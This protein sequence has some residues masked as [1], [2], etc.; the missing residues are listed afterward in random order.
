MGKFNNLITSWENIREFDLRPLRNAA[1]HPV[2]IA[3]VGEPGCGRHTLADQM[4]CD[5]ARPHNTT[6]TPLIFTDLQSPEAALGANLIILITDSR[7]GWSDREQALLQHWINAEKKVL[8][9]K[10]LWHEAPEDKAA[11]PQSLSTGE[12]L[13]AGALIN[14]QFI[15]HS[16]VPSVLSLLPDQHVALGRQFPLFRQAIA[17]RL[18]DDTCLSNAAYALSTGIAEAIPIFD[19]P[20]NVTDLIVL[21]KTQAFLAYKLG[22][23]FGFSTNWQDYVAEFGSVL[24]A[25]F[26]WRQMARLMVGLV[27]VW[28]LLPKV[29]IS[30]AGTYVVGHSILQWYLTGKNISNQQIQALYQEALHAGKSTAQKLLQK[31]SNSGLKRIT[32]NPLRR[33]P[34]FNKTSQPTTSTPFADLKARFKIKKTDLPTKTCSHCHKTSAADASFCQYCGQTL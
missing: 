33:L 23:T 16:F 5:P 7:R 27:P 4:R 11:S 15:A 26:L 20:L 34:Y 21:T 31:V 3:L 17:R 2:K 28:G 30:Y 19:V 9:I 25:G 32:T 14:P 18:I 8:V 29:A 1:Q 10:N 22:L 13:L 6:Q 12:H 24:G